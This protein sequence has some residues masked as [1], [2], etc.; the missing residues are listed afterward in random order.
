M[1][2]TLPLAGS[3]LRVRTA[4]RIAL[5]AGLLLQAGLRP[6]VAAPGPKVRRAAPETTATGILLNHVGFMP[7][8]EKTF[9]LAGP[10]A[11]RFEAL[12]A[13]GKT[14]FQGEAVQFNKDFGPWRVGNFSALNKP[15]SYR[16]RIAGETSH[17]FAISASL[18][19]DAIGKTLTYFAAQRCGDSTTG[20]HHPCHLDDGRR[21]DN[22]QHQDVSGGWHDACDLR[23]WSHATLYGMTGLARVAEVRGRDTARIIDELRWGNS[24][25]LKLQEPAGYIMNY[26][27]GD[28]GNH[29]TD[30]QTGNQDD[31]PIHTGP[32]GADIQF[33]FIA[34]QASMVALTRQADPAYSARC[35]E[36]ATRCLKWVMARDNTKS[37]LIAA[38]GAVACCELRRAMPDLEIEA[39][40]GKL[41]AALV[42]MQVTRDPDPQTPIRG[43]FTRSANPSSDGNLPLLAL[44]QLLETFPNHPDAARW[45]AALRLHCDYLLR[46]SQRNPFGLI[47]IELFKGPAAAGARPLG[48][49]GYRYFVS[50]KRDAKNREGWWVGINAHLASNGVGLARASR[51]LSDPRLRGLAQRQLDWIIGVNP[52]DASTME[53]VGR[54]QP[55][56]FVS[57]EF[58]PATPHIPGAVMNGI[59]GRADDSP[60]LNAGSW[61]TCEYWTP[62]VCYTMWLMAELEAAG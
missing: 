7:G 24:Y 59:G 38:W 3:T 53:D 14:V 22:G 58:R 29:W 10:G 5:F 17:P 45:K 20:Y 40:A 4:V 61:Q 13:D 54:N 62:M 8:A 28:D 2:P 31:R 43:A 36:A 48:T 34:A 51:L 30:N 37:A 46:I 19:E 26:C 6:A 18:H 33:H 15:G 23:K 1:K 35:R 56:Q 50:V 57:S 21:L 27:G 11:T 44:C 60:F 55:R 42:A 41:A 39:E 9:L 52:F 49:Y 12:D 47:P 32:T 16:I 25:F